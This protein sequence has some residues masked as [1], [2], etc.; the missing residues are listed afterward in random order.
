MCVFPLTWSFL[1]SCTLP[2]THRQ[3]VADY[4]VHESYEVD[5]RDN[6]DHTFCGIM[7][8][9]YVRPTLP[10]EFIEIRSVSVR[11]M[12][13][14]MT[15]WYSLGDFTQAH[16]FNTRTDASFW[17]RIYKKDLEPSMRKFQELIFPKPLI[18]RPGEFAY[19]NEMHR[20]NERGWHCAL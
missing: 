9:I 4:M 8:P 13:G 2:P 18:V 19:M 5:T 15:V 20:A 3:T 14:G 10:V 1:L 17:T 16:Q 11:G 6:E 12:L 7:F